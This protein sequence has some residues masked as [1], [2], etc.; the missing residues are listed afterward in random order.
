MSY[1][2]EDVLFLASTKESFTIKTLIDLLA[3]NFTNG[4][5][6]ISAEGIEFNM[7]EESANSHMFLLKLKNTDF[8]R[9][10]Y[11]HSYPSFNLGVNLTHVYKMIKSI[12]KKDLIELKILK[13][14]LNQLHITIVPKD[15]TRH[16]SSTVKLYD[17][18]SI[19]STSIEGYNHYI[20]VSTTEFFRSLKELIV[21]SMELKVT[22]YP[23]SISF[24]AEIDSIYSKKITFGE[25]PTAQQEETALFSMPYKLE[26]FLKINKL[27]S[28]ST[29]INIAYSETSPLRLTC[30]F[31]LGTFTVF[32][33]PSLSS[34]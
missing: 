9:F 25:T 17:M 12:K 2:E 8:S 14:E 20:I 24:A 19:K 7:I 31:E 34:S 21:I 26:N 23:K 28:L 15:N 1:R 10:E 13:T 4:C 16:H 33:H 32:I 27:P 22:F 11:N 30:K 29:N 18:Q 3:F 6:I 5:F